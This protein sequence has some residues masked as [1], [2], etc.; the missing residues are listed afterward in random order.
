MALG[1]MVL[2]AAVI[3]VGSFVYVYATAGSGQA[4]APISAP[5]LVSSS[6]TQQNFEIDSNS[7]KVQ[8][9]LTEELLGKPTTVVGTTNQVAGDILGSGKGQ[10]YRKSRM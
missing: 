6:S 8:F 5:A 1:V 10:G 9:T 4:S 7:S 3:A 2:I